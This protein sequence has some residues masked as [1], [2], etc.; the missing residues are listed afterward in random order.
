[1]TAGSHA[2]IGEVLSQLRA[3]F[4]D[5]T[6]SKLR[7]LESAGLVEPNRTAAGY[8][9]YS[10]EDVARLRYVLTAQRDHYL[11]LK[12][13]REQLDAID[14]GVMLNPQAASIP[15]RGAPRRLL[16]ALESVEANHGYDEAEGITES[17]P[18]GRITREQLRDLTEADESLLGSLE[19]FGLVTADPRGYF[20]DHDVAIVRA[21]SGLA[22]YGIE[23]RHLRA[24]RGA[25][26]REVGLFKQVVT[27][28][29]RQ[30]ARSDDGADPARDVA[31][32]LCALS[33]ALHEA[34]MRSTLDRVL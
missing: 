16:R 25:A 28:I 19:Q 1:M 31:T 34:L 14:S 4:P 17:V 27:P 3:E 18:A 8:R 5:T 6:V 32:E 22:G 7:F 24:F 21:A 12:V 26:D 15:P 29:A 30:R 10:V 23:P 9:K 2:S 13:I 33:V 11:P 20:T